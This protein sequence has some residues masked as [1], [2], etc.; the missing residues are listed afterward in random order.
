[1]TH[2]N[3]L[4]TI[5][6]S[7]HNDIVVEKRCAKFVHSYLSINKLVIKRAFISA[8]TTHNSQFGDNYMIFV[9][10]ER[11]YERYVSLSISNVLQ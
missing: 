9:T 4:P 11:F 7:I 3:L 2:C 6:N 10:N 1:M 8:I 5:N